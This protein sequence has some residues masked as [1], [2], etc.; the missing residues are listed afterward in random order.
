MNFFPFAYNLCEV[1]ADAFNRGK[2]LAGASSAPV[3]RGG[4]FTGFI[5][6]LA[7]Q[8]GKRLLEVDE[9]CAIFEHIVKGQRYFF[10]VGPSVGGV[11]CYMRSRYEF[12]PHSVPEPVALAVQN[13]NA[14]ERRFQFRV[15][16]LP[17]KSFC[18]AETDLPVEHFD[19]AMLNEVAIVLS[20]GIYA[21]DDTMLRAGFVR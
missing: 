16:N 11:N 7:H 21:L 8:S 19:A 14:T 13:H 3:H 12:A 6:Q 5:Q 2:A 9:E 1:V 4:S 15:V 17:S 10:I 20:S 18:T